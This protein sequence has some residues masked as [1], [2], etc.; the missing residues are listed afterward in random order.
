MVQGKESL[1]CVFQ[2]GSLDRIRST[3]VKRSFAFLKDQ[4]LNGPMA[5]APAQELPRETCATPSDDPLCPTKNGFLDHRLEA[6]GP[7]LPV[8]AGHKG[9]PRRGKTRTGGR[10]SC[11]FLVWFLLAATVLMVG[12]VQAVFTPGDGT[13]LKAAVNSCV[14]FSGDGSACA[15]SSYGAIGEWDVSKVTDMNSSTSSSV[16]SRFVHWTVSLIC[17]FDFFLIHPVLFV[18]FASF[19][20]LHLFCAHCYLRFGWCG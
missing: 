5:F 1:V 7:R 10:R 18:V 12:V 2:S 13:A 8:A 4:M 9:G 16:S 6:V 15:S 14:G 3:L 19:L 11:T 17:C 20:A